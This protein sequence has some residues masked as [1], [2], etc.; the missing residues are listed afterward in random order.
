MIM[1]ARLRAIW[2]TNA[3]YTA[4]DANSG[5]TIAGV[6][7]DV[8][9]KLNQ[10]GGIQDGDT[11]EYYAMVFKPY[12]VTY[13]D[14]HGI[15]VKVD[16][17]YVLASQTTN[18]TYT[19]TENYIPYPTGE[20]GVVAQFLGWQQI[21]PEVEGQMM[22]HNVGDPAFPLTQQNYTLR[23]HTQKGHWLIFD[24]N[25]SNASYTE[26]QFIT[27]GGTTV[28]PTNAPTRS[29][30]TFNGW[31][32]EDADSDERDGRVAGVQ[33]TFG[34][35]LTENT[36]VYGKWTGAST[37]SYN[38]VIWY[39]NTSGT[40]Y[41]YSGT[42]Y[43]V[44]NATVGQNTY[45]ITVQNNNNANTRYARIYGRNNNQNQYWGNSAIN[46]L[47]LVTGPCTGTIRIWWL[48]A[49]TPSP[50]IPRIPS[51]PSRTSSWAK[52]AMPPSRSSSPRSLPSSLPGPS[53]KPTT[54]STT[55]RS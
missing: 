3:N 32:T 22:L 52:A 30:Y 38:V 27:I 45:Q 12:N 17:I 28:T 41:D 4:A 5:K 8:T 18:P 2:T 43:K 35:E 33:F 44:E 54:R 40:G 19:V 7:E 11:L 50:W 37:A 42:T 21:E 24:E 10:A 20:E 26:P 39:Q 1:M 31:Y 23:A 51:P 14:E 9:A 53:G 13:L 29:G 34:N 15:M 49:R 46:P 6:R 36:T 48:R 47:R 25:L 16:Q 55:T